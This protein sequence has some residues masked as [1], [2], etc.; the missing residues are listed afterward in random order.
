MPVPSPPEQQAAYAA[1]S[2]L[3]R[4]DLARLWTKLNL[5]APA[6]LA[7][8]LTEILDALV[9]RYGQAAASLAADWYE[10]A[11]A[12]AGVSGSFTA[13]TAPL[14]ET[15]RLGALSRWGVGPLFGADP[16][17]AL[18]LSLLSGGL[19]RLVTGMGRQ[20]TEMSAAADPKI[21][22]YARHASAN[23]CEFCR[24]LATRGADFRY[25]SE[26]SAGFVTGESLGGTDYR[27]I[28]RTGVSS[29]DILSGRKS[30][31]STKRPIGEKY[32]D[33]C[34]CI[35]VPIWSNADYEPPSYVE[36]WRAEYDSAHQ[37]GDTLKQTLARMRAGA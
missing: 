35:P 5:G 10:D 2:K 16:N 24:V 30:R 18:A 33:D 19:Q 21:I 15:D 27:K 13:T 26:Q 28:R 37:P 6:K 23:A 8:P 20:T 11:R 1:L 34:H 31:S 25:T 29:S 22:G 36:Q 4:R 3:S 7:D 9:S 17:G 32:H 12:A 14:P